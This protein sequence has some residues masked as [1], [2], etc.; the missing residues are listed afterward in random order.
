MASYNSN[1][2]TENGFVHNGP[3]DNRATG[4]MVNNNG[5]TTW[6]TSFSPRARKI[7]VGV[8]VL[9]VVIVVVVPTVTVTQT[10]ARNRATQA[11]SWRRR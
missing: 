6:W 1:S 2:A 5:S 3:E 4:G 9:V 11:N 8:I 10:S 7:L